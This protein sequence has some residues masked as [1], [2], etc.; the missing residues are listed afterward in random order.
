MSHRSTPALRYLAPLLMLGLVL[1]MA[2]GTVAAEE[3]TV[4]T[5]IP[6]GAYEITSTDRGNEVAIEG[7]GRLLVP[8]MPNLP[9]RMAKGNPASTM[10]IA[11]SGNA[12]FKW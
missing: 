11:T 5:P 8:G 2:S 7:Y 4:S 10:I 12:S 6:V 1:L 9:A 3:L